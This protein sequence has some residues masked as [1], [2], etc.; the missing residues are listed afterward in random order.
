MERLDLVDSEG[1]TIIP[2]HLNQEI[3]GSGIP[4][5]EHWNSTISPTPTKA[6]IGG[7]MISGATVYQQ[8]G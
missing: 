2:I 3:V 4:E 6:L 1:N 8:I 7:M 5:T